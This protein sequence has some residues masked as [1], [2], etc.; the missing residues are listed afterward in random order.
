MEQ[1]RARFL[2]PIPHRYVSL[3][4]G[5]TYT[6]RAFWTDVI[7]QV[8]QNQQL[9]DCAVLVDWARVASTFGLPNPAGQNMTL[10]GGGVG[11]IRVPLAD[12][13]LSARR[14]LWLCA[15]LPALSQTG[16]PLERHFVQQ[17]ATFGLILARQG[18]EAAAF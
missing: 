2:C 16:T 18:D 14:W 1:L 15:D 8:A 4:I 3:C 11:A 9:Q 12:E 6:P 13:T 5:H 17:S 7:G 10:L